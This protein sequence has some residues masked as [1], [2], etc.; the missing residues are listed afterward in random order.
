MTVK[1]KRTFCAVVVIQE[2]F[3]SLRNMLECNDCRGGLFVHQDGRKNQRQDGAS[4][5]QG[6][7]SGPACFNRGELMS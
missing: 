4:H 1:D 3:V 5:D 7:T 6:A 2:S